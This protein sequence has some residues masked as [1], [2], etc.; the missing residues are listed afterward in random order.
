[1]QSSRL[2]TLFS[3]PP[4][5]SSGPSAFFVSMMFHNVAIVLLYLGLKHMP[6]V[7][8]ISLAQ[9]KYTVRL[10][11]LRSSD[12][13]I[14]WSPRS[15]AT[16]PGLQTAAK[17]VSPGGSRALP[18]IPQLLAQNVTPPQTLVQPDLPPNLLS[19]H[20]I[21][22]PQV[23]MWT[24]EK[25]PVKQIVPPPPHEDA[26]AN[27]QP[28]LS[29]PNH[30][31][32]PADVKISTSAFTTEL[33][34]L[35]PSTTSPIAVHGSQPVQLVPET[36]STLVEQSAPASVVSL[37]EIRM[38]E[39]SIVL[40]AI[41]E[42][43]LS[44]TSGS[45]APGS[46]NGKSQAGNGNIGS[47]QNGV[48]TGQDSGEKATKATVSS[49]GAVHPGANARANQTAEAS[50][51]SGNKPGVQR[52]SLPKDGQFGVVVV[53]S[54]LAEEY[55]ETSGVWSGR[56]AYTVY[57]HLGLAK[58]WILQYS[59]PRNEEAS[60]AGAPIRPDAPWPYDIM[61]PNLEDGSDS[62][63]VMIHGFVDTTGHFEHL[64]VLYPE[65]FAQTEFLLSSLQQWKFRPAMQNGQAAEVE[66]LLI[67][68]SQVE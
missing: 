16:P 39:G 13:Q 21:P 19:L 41:N 64:A 66:V 10:V 68:P 43:S 57:L 29:P 18:S 6:M 24:P 35:S 62:D 28:S 53:G 20:Q 63:T 49:T 54:S 47:K 45:L 52:I 48:G 67:I 31:L 55:P 60:A 61:R 15:Q 56:L 27:V 2:I 44:S 40:P 46:P 51:G 33:P 58:S 34:A 14:Q 38:A 25:V 12:A 17:A 9:Q 23:L 5:P 32:I 8:H 65:E 3:E 30:E 7:Y 26:S 11:K 22:V 4:P 59:L 1:M 37:S 42:T 36:T 50:L